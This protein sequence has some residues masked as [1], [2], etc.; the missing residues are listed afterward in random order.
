MNFD[1]EVIAIID[2][3][4]QYVSITSKRHEQFLNIFNLLNTKKKS[5][6]S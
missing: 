3:L 5:K 1:N 2:N 6:T 4:L